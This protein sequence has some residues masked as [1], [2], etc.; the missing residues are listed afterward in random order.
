MVR[1]TSFL[2][3]IHNTINTNINGIT[4]SSM[5]MIKFQSCFIYT[6]GI[7]ACQIKLKES[8]FFSTRGIPTCIEVFVFS[9]VGFIPVS[10]RVSVNV[11]VG[12]R[13]QTNEDFVSLV[14][15]FPGFIPGS[16]IEDLKFPEAVLIDSYPLPGGQDNGRF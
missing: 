7:D 2:P 11:G 8:S 12:D 15:Y 14:I 6:V 5:L 1:A 4:Y 9:P 10:V 3:W 13:F 16:G